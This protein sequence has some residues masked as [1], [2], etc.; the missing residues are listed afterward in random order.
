MMTKL[1]SINFKM[2]FISY[3]FLCCILAFFSYYNQGYIDISLYDAIFFIIPSY[4]FAYRNNKKSGKDK[5]E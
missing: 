2:F 5:E 1:L 3:I 4:I